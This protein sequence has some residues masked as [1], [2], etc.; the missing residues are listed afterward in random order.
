MRKTGLEE[1]WTAALEERPGAEEQG[2]GSKRRG[3]RKQ[4][5]YD[6]DG[7]ATQAVGQGGVIEEGGTNIENKHKKIKTQKL[8]KHRKKKS[9]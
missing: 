5:C 1:G 9:N 8:P 7:G 6:F 4:T 2:K 3:G